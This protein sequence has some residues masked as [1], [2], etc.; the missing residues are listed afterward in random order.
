MVKYAHTGRHLAYIVTVDPE[1]ILEHFKGI[2]IIEA[3]YPA[4]VAFPKLLVVL[5]YLHILTNRYERMAAKVLAGIILATWISYTIATVFQCS[6]IAFSWNKTLPMGRCFNIRAYLN[7][8]SAPN[9]FTDLVVLLLPLRTVWGL[10]ISTGRRVGLLMIF[11]M[12]G[13]YVYRSS[14]AYAVEQYQLT[15]IAE[16]LSLQS[17]AQSSSP[18]RLENPAP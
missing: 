2:L 16:A 8:S 11:L 6:P 4:A 1:R 10:K 17:S 12:G 7:S 13:M 5:M 3:T 9:I 18:E 14:F 15:V